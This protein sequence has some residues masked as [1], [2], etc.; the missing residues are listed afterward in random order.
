M[1]ARSPPTDLVLCTGMV[2]ILECA[3]GGL[4]PPVQISTVSSW[5]K[6][7][8]FP[9]LLYFIL[10]FCVYA[11]EWEAICTL[12]RLFHI[13]F[14]DIT[15]HK[16]N[17]SG[18]GSI[19]PTNAT[20]CFDTEAALMFARMTLTKAILFG[21]LLS[22]QILKDYVKCNSPSKWRTKKL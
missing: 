8:L 19:C 4:P 7:L 16:L 3:L 2:R 11:L 17:S 13:S 21:R 22:N 6:Y 15:S 20:V 10:Y 14:F 5:W 12:R 1:G 18:H 9:L